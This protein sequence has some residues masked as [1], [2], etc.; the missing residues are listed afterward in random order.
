MLEIIYKK[1]GSEV[2]RK[3]LEEEFKSQLDELVDS[4]RGRRISFFRSVVPNIDIL[5]WVVLAACFV[6]FGASFFI[7]MEIP[8]VRPCIVF[9]LGISLLCTI[10]IIINNILKVYRD[11]WH[12]RDFI[13][14]V[15][16]TEDLFK[17]NYLTFVA[18]LAVS[19]FRE[20]DVFVNYRSAMVRDFCKLSEL[21]D[22][23]VIDYDL[24][25]DE[26]ILQIKYIDMNRNMQSI[27]IVLDNVIDSNTSKNSLI[28]SDE[29]FVLEKAN[30]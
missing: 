20:F 14:D 8:E 12:F 29:G 3:C 26:M 16:E 2:S 17:K 28:C 23:V 18:Q 11:V 6:L 4:V 30:A 1:K 5:T 15:K 25:K 7:Y 10:T 9:I 19:Q 22:K 13:N 27:E 21:S 24:K